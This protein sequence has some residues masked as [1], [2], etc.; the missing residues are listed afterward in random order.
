MF[1][2]Q[3]QVFVCLVKGAYVYNHVGC[4]FMGCIDKC[5]SVYQ[6]AGN[7]ASDRAD[8]QTCSYMYTHGFSVRGTAAPG[9]L[10]AG[11]R[12]GSSARRGPVPQEIEGNIPQ[13]TSGLP[14]ASL[15]RVMLWTMK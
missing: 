6:F 12:K 10:C 13:I 3:K 7:P 9:E 15:P 14:P 11:C 1:G 8:R 4:S 2:P 5:A